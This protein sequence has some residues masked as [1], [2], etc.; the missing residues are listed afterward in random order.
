[1]F[2]AIYEAPSAPTDQTFQQKFTKH[3]VDKSII[4]KKLIR[5]KDLVA[6]SA[7]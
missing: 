5:S 6:T 4:S 2:L 1:M 3:K 7:L